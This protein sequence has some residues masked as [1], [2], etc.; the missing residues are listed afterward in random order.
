MKLTF[1]EGFLWGAATASYQVEGGIENNDWAEAGREGKVPE[2]GRS[3]DHY[4][5]FETDFDIAKSLGHTAHRIS[6]EW[7]RIE[8]Q[9]GVFD[10][11]EVAHYRQVLLALRSRGLEPF[12]TL[13]H[14]TLP[15]WLT[16]KGGVASKEFPKFF[17][18]YSAYITKQLG[19]YATHWSTINEPLVFSGMGWVRGIWPPFKYRAYISF[20]TVLRNLVRAHKEAYVVIKKQNPALKVS[21]VKHNKYFHSS[22]PIVLAPLVALN[23]WFWNRWFLNKTKHCL[24]EIGLNYYGHVEFFKRAQYPKTDFGWDIYPE[25]LYHVLKELKQYNLP[26]VISESGCADKNDTF[27]AD[28]IRNHLKACHRAITDGVP[29]YGYFYWSLLDNFEW[30][31]GYTMRFGLVEIDYQTLERKIRPSTQV[32]KQ[33]CETNML[34]L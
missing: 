3:S 2:A 15:L 24:D 29:L 12:I 9:E 21:V 25:G 33:I 18:R 13:W 1:P 27:R 16:E 30:A 22:I 23:R 31:E 14:F 4:H 10:E 19:E 32:Y 5:R 26:I 6:I 7:S 20:F 34:E 17:S 28:F 11:K 8:P